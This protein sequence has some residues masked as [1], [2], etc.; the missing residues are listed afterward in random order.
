MRS[1]PTC[2]R[3]APKV[4]TQCAGDASPAGGGVL[5]NGVKS[6]RERA[7]FARCAVVGSVLP[8]TSGESTGRDRAREI[9]GHTAVFRFNDAP[10]AG[11]VHRNL[12][13]RKTT[14]RIQ[15]DVYLGWAERDGEMCLGYSRVGVEAGR[16]RTTGRNTVG[17][18]G[19]GGKCVVLPLAEGAVRLASTFWMRWLQDDDDGA[20]GRRWSGGSDA[21]G[22]SGG[23]GGARTTKSSPP[24]PPPPPPL[25]PRRVSAGFFGV[26]LALNLCAEVDVYGFGS[27]STTT[28]LIRGGTTGKATS[29]AGEARVTA[30]TRGG[31]LAYPDSESKQQQQQ[32]KNHQRKNSSSQGPE[33]Q[34]AGH[35]RHYYNKS[36]AARRADPTRTP[37]AM[38]HH[39][40][41][42]RRCVHD[43]LPK[44]L[45]T[46][47]FRVHP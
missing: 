23:A 43:I 14:I 34:A 36:D 5:A 24:P 10:T 26:L 37:T 11:S 20:A 32:K 38:R 35:E 4:P 41:R 16:G 7:N 17:G 3:S 22:S 2:A 25:A 18:G 31:D 45:G 39:W 47:K 21:E 13:G 9:D 33:G 1:S 40:D 44:W 27:S 15:N 42:E 46:A 19:G 8:E 12:V 30:T 6:L 28:T 29:T